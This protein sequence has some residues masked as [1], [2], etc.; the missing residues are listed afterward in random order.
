MFGRKSAVLPP[1][2]PCLLATKSKSQPIGRSIS[3]D[4]THRRAALSPLRRERRRRS[5]CISARTRS[6]ATSANGR[7][8][9]PTSTARRLRLGRPIASHVLLVARAACLFPEGEPSER[10]PSEPGARQG[11]NH[12]WG[13]PH[14]RRHSSIK[15]QAPIEHQQLLIDQRPRAAATTAKAA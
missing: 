10:E 12:T 8:A 6:R 11:V 5:A 3:E 14:S 7:P 4:V 15:Y 9:L 1:R 13:T 2:D